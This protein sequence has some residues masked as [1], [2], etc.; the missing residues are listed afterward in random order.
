[1]LTA[2][3]AALAFVPLA[4]NVFWGPLAVALIGGLAVATAL[5][6]IAL[7]ALYALWFRVPRNAADDKKPV[8]KTEHLAAGYAVAAE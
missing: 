8:P 5:T 6:L 2:L 4:T 3:A 1:V 7:P